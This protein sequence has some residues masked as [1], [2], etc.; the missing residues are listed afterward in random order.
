[1]SGRVRHT[2]YWATLQKYDINANL[3]GAIEHLYDKAISAV[4]M[5]GSTG[6]Q[7]RETV[8]VRQRCF[9]HQPSSSFFLKG[10]CLMIGKTTE[11][12]P[13][14]RFAD[15]DALLKNGRN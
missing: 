2:S 4:Q 13:S 9:S 15:I 14:L 7:F 12:L 8:G 6:D 1:M 10:F 3:V 11:L 5:Y